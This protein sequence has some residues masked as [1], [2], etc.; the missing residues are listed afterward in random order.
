MNVFNEKTHNNN[1]I[2]KAIDTIID[3]KIDTRIDQYIQSIKYVYNY[4]MNEKN[5]LYN[6]VRKTYTLNYL[7]NLLIELNDHTCL[8]T[9][10]TLRK[11]YIDV[12]FYVNRQTAEQLFH[13]QAPS[14]IHRQASSTIHSKAQPKT[15]YEEKQNVHNYTIQTSIY[16]I[17]NYLFKHYST[18]NIIIL[19]EEFVFLYGN[20]P[21][22]LLDQHFAFGNDNPFTLHDIL[23]CIFYY[24]ETHVNISK[25][26]FFKR[27]YDEL[28]DIKKTKC[29]TTGKLGRIIS[30]I[31]GLSDDEN[32]QIKMSDQER[33]FAIIQHYLN[34]ELKYAP[35]CIQDA[36]IHKEKKYR[37]FVLNK[38]EEKKNEWNREHGST[39]YL[40]V[41][42]CLKKYYL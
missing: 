26:T 9:D 23:N 36:M 10:S 30:S 20:E 29:C 41:D 15:I 18:S 13:Q 32:I 11:E 6:Y 8:S 12:F 3:K 4:S 33:Y 7:T 35:E 28:M 1:L 40:Y 19:K 5:R 39:F 14:T 21:I 25:D 34:K 37:E 27:L 22:S 16:E 24:V 42:K 31:Q 17:A 2:M 38:I